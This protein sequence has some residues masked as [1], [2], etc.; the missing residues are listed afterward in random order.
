MSKKA[1][2]ILGI[3]IVIIG[4]LGFFPIP[5]FVAAWWYA[6]IKIIIGALA[7]LISLKK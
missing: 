7:V 1:L 6:V 5:I 3:I 2:M 4:V